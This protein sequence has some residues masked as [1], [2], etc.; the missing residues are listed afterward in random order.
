MAVYKIAPLT[1]TN[2]ETTTYRTENYI[3]AEKCRSLCSK[4]KDCKAFLFTSGGKLNLPPKCELKN[5]IPKETFHSS[6]AT[7]FI[8]NGSP[9]Y[10]ILWLF[11]IAL[12]IVI[13]VSGCKQKNF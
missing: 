10:F 3:S 2:E 4:D 8:K 5:A 9:S 1:S 12:V 7:L 6:S 13:F 11:L